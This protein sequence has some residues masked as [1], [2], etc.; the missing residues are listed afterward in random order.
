MNA[1]QMFAVSAVHPTFVPIQAVRIFMIVDV[2]DLPN[3]DSWIENQFVHEYLTFTHNYS[4]LTIN[5]LDLQISLLPDNVIC[6]SLY[7]KPMCKH[8][9]LHYKSNHTKS[10]LKSIPYSQGLRIIKLCS[11][12]NDCISHLSNL[13]HQFVIRGY[14]KNILQITLNKLLNI[15]RKELLKP[16]G[17][18]LISHLRLF[19]S[20]IL[21]QFNFQSCTI[22]SENDENKVFVVFPFHNNIPNFKSIFIDKLKSMISDCRI[23]NIK[24]CVNSLKIVI[25]YKKTNS[26]GNIIK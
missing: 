7:K 14:P 3:I 9:Y 26:I 17:S 22:N 4:P 13:M 2:T 6:T 10:L 20:D 21:E 12:T 15:Q 11:N 25:S 5:F 18:N 19:N 23:T 1:N 16:K 8:L 24:D